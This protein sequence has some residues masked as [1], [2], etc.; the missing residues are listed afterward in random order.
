MILVEIHTDKAPRRRISILR[1]VPERTSYQPEPQKC[2]CG[3]R[4]IQSNDERRRNEGGA[5]AHKRGRCDDKYEK[6]A[7][8]VAYLSPAL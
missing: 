5:Q 1:S 7:V 2:T 4:T 6:A 8:K 3:R